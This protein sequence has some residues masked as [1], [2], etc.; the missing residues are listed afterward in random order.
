MV[1]GVPATIEEREGKSHY[2]G[3][4][5]QTKHRRIAHA[6]GLAPYEGLL[7][8]KPPP[9][10]HDEPPTHRFARWSLLTAMCCLQEEAGTA[11]W[12]NA[13]RFPVT[14]TPPSRA[15]PPS[16]WSLAGSDRRVY[17]PWNSVWPV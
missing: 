5:L 10:A 11:G 16:S 7:P 8:N 17:S 6:C 15:D 1:T 2:H 13:P 14:H 12:Y 4:H 3:F 9:T